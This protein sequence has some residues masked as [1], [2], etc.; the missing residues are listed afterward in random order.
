MR[1][2]FIKHFKEIENKEGASYYSESNEKFSLSATF[3]KL[4]LSRIGIHHETLEPGHRTSFPHAEADGEEFVYVL[5]GAPDVWID[6][7]LHRLKK[8]EGVVFSAGTGISH[9]FINNTDQNVRLLVVGERIAGSRVFYPMNP[10]RKALI[11][12]KWWDGVAGISMGPHS[13]M[14]D[15]TKS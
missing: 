5:E 3:S 7:N 10:S 4:G 1:P 15:K 8:D 12:K 13:G 2:P 14:P 11:G 6:G 9:T